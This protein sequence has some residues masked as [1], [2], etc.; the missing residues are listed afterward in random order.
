MRAARSAPK[1][2]FLGRFESAH[3]KEGERTLKLY[4]LHNGVKVAIIAFEGSRVAPEEFLRASAKL[5]DFFNKGTREDVFEV[6]IRPEAVETIVR[7][8]AAFNDAPVP[9]ASALS[10]LLNFYRDL[11]SG[12]P[13]GETPPELRDL[14]NALHQLA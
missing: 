12:A 10:D 5:R 1:Y 2:L 7:A 9:L 3:I 14:L 6:T 8:V 13:H 4:L 11:I